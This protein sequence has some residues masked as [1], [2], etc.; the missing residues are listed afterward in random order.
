MPE[1]LDSNQEYLDYEET[2][3]AIIKVSPY[4][5]DVVDDEN[6]PTILMEIKDVLDGDAIYKDQVFH[7]NKD[8]PGYTEDNSLFEAVLTTRTFTNTEA[9]QIICQ[10]LHEYDKKTD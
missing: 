7:L 1:V 4:A 10:D 6:S 3:R 8:M 2:I 9:R 5:Y